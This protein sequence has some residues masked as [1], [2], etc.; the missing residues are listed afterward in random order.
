VRAPAERGYAA[1]AIT[2]GAYG[3]T[4]YAAS[5]PARAS[6]DTAAQ[7]FERGIERQRQEVGEAYGDSRRAEGGSYQAAPPAGG[8][9][10]ARPSYSS[11]YESSAAAPSDEPAKPGLLDRFKE[12]QAYDRLQQEVQTLGSRAVEELSKTAQQVVL[13]ALLGKLKDLIGIDLSTQREVAQRSRL[14]HQT[15]ATRAQADQADQASQTDQPAAGGGSQ[16]GAA[17]GAYAGGYGKTL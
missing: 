5:A 15:A 3:S 2:G 4:A 10:E 14:E 17:G 13:P 1:Q 8:L 12:T 11:G 6:A 7:A 16:P 9:S